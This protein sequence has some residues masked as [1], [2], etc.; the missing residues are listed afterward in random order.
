[1]TTFRKLLIVAAAATASMLVAAQQPVLAH[2]GTVRLPSGDDAKFTHSGTRYWTAHHLR[3][4]DGGK[5]DGAGVVAWASYNA[6]PN[7]LSQGA[8]APQN[9]VAARKGSGTCSRRKRIKVNRPYSVVVTVC[10]HDKSEDGPFVE[11]RAKA[12]PDD[13]KFRW[14]GP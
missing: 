8:W 12:T 7:L 9:Y 3:V 6:D 11:W 1:M 4:C 14:F 5:R 10:R 2:G 13:C